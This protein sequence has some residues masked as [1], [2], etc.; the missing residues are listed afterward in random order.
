MAA[1]SSPSS[2]SSRPPAA[3]IDGAS[4]LKRRRSSGV[5]GAPPPPEAERA[6]QRVDEEIQWRMKSQL[7]DGEERWLRPLSGRREEKAEGGRGKDKKE[8]SRPGAAGPGAVAGGKK[9]GGKEAAMST[10]AAVRAVVVA[11][12]SPPAEASPQDSEEQE[13]EPMPHRTCHNGLPCL[14]ATGGRGANGSGAAGRRRPALPLTAATVAFAGGGALVSQIT[15]L[16]YREQRERLWFTNPLNNVF[17]DLC[18]RRGPQ[19]DG[20]LQGP[21][22]CGQFM[23]DKFFCNECAGDD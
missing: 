17:C 10:A 15:V 22:G 5:G 12:P 23:Q 18:H 8:V 9:G 7:E 1:K 16:S 19:Q 3:D 13:A 4:P 2:S 14:R 6:L 11:S 20:R 21:P